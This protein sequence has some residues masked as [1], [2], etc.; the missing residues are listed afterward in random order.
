MP[1]HGGCP[2]GSSTMAGFGFSG[3]HENINQLVFQHMEDRG[4]L[5]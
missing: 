2:G 3:G 4:I 5:I 1:V